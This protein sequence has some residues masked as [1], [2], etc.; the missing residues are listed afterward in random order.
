M[1]SADYRAE[2]RKIVITSIRKEFP[3]LKKKQLEDAA[4][5][6]ARAIHARMYGA[7]VDG[8]ESPIWR[9]HP[10]TDPEVRAMQPTKT[11]QELL[12]E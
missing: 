9:D 5:S 8:V 2:I 4:T 1:N 12:N 3:G 11:A 7:N 6:A 10:W